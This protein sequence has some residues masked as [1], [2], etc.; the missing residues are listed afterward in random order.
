MPSSPQLPQTPQSSKTPL[1]PRTKMPMPPQVKQRLF[2]ALAIVFG[3]AVGVALTLMALQ[4][5]VNYFYSPA[6]LMAAAPEAG[7]GFR[8]GGMVAEGSVQQKAGTPVI[9]FTVTDYKAER[10]VRYTGIL[11]DL[12]REGQGVVAEGRL[13]AD[14]TFVADR[15]LAKHDEKYMPPEV[16]DALKR[17]KETPGHGDGI[18]KGAGK[19]DAKAAPPAGGPQTREGT[20]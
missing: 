2:I 10:K 7:R 18:G 15:L 3:V 9:Q 8:L 12:F 4:R 11:P 1:R 20:P 17:A 6:D 19:G 13:V 14:G 5:N 16:A